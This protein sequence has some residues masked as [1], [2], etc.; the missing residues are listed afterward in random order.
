[1]VRELYE[2]HQPCTPTQ[3]MM[4]ETIA[5]ARWRQDR[6]WEMQKE[7]FDYDIDSSESANDSAPLRAILTLRKSPE[8]VRSHELL[9][10]YETALDR[11]I[12]RSLL[13]LQ[14]LQEKGAL[15][16]SNETPKGIALTRSEPDEA[17]RAAP[18]LP[19]EN[20]APAKRTRQ[21]VESKDTATGPNEDAPQ[22][23]APSKA[24][25]PASTNSASNT[26]RNQAKRKQDQLSSA[27]RRLEYLKLRNSNPTGKGQKPVA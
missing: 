12:S 26:K 21:S 22:L 9:L 4:V 17:N 18:I 14:Q 2:E 10:R 1:M 5:S 13:R 3:E 23:S 19:P 8:S 6:I 24:P 27:V 25:S 20:L 7:A 15:R 16:G 11:Q